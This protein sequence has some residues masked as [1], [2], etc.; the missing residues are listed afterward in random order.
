MTVFVSPDS[1]KGSLSFI[2]H[3]LSSLPH[4]LPSIPQ[5]PIYLETHFCKGCCLC[6]YKKQRYQTE[7]HFSTAATE[8]TTLPF[9][10]LLRITVQIHADERKCSCSRERKSNI[11]NQKAFVIA[12]QAHVSRNQFVPVPILLFPK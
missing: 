4:P 9:L 8:E 3:P 12:T 5:P 2:L 11:P 1:W 10:F 7:H 6:L